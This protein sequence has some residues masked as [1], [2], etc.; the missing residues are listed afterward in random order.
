MAFWP[1]KTLLSAVELDLFSKLAKQT[2]PVEAL[3]DR[4]GLN[5]RG[6]RDFFDTLVSLGFLHRDDSG[7]YSNTAE[8]DAFLDKAKPSYIGGMLEMTNSRLYPHWGKL[9]QA[10]KTGLPQSEVADN[11]DFFAGLYAEPDRLREFLSAMTGVSRPANIG[12]AHCEEINWTSRQTVVDAGTAQGDLV[13]QIAKANPHLQGIGFDLPQ[14]EPV[15]NEYI[16][17]GGVADRV[18]F[19]PGDFFA[20]DLPKADVVLMGHILHDWDLKEK[21]HL[22]RRAYDALEEGGVFVVYDALIDDDRRVNAFGLMMSLNMLVETPGG[23]DYT[24]ADGVGWML[25]GGFREAKVCRLSD[26][27]A[28]ILATK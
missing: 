14:V 20:G 24:G 3:A 19:Q 6:A 5:L 28:I 13:L 23:F 27:A 12:I 8:T 25:E 9:T 1:A 16:Q 2:D 26:K 4:L 18:S 17:K 7:V 10:L 22:I 11:P 21:K 15:F